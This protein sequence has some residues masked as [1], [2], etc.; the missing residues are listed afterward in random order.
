MASRLSPRSA[1][2]PTLYDR[3]T[4]YAVGRRH[5]LGS[6]LQQHRAGWSGARSLSTSR[7]GEKGQPAARY[8]MLSND[9]VRCRHV[10]QKIFRCRKLHA[11]QLSS[12]RAAAI[13]R[14]RASCAGA[15]E[16][17]IERSG[18]HLCITQMALTGR[19]LLCIPSEQRTDGRH[20]DFE[21][22]RSSNSQ[23]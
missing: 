19:K 10:R 17:I 11:P 3:N 8:R 20:G 22:P 21:R 1:S 6:Y 18:S 13:D 9:G 15:P 23:G 16:P 12:N 4:R 5:Y 7:R 2:V 14:T